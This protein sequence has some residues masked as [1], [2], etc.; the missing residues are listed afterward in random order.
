MGLENINLFNRPVWP[1]GFDRPMLGVTQYHTE[2]RQWRNDGH[3]TTISAFCDLC[4][5]DGLP[6]L[7]LSWNGTDCAAVGA[8]H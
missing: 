5:A 7:T 6:Q 4:K 3:A 2:D 8:H 1:F